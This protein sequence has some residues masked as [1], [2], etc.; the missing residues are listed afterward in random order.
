MK[1][2][3]ANSNSRFNIS[4]VAVVVVLFAVLVV[5]FMV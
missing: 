5:G 2:R 1:A 4:C 3:K